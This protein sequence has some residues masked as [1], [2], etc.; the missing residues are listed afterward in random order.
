MSTGY[1]F[2]L[3]EGGEIV[4]VTAC[5]CATDADALL[6]ADVVLQAS[7]YPAVEIWS[8]PRRVGMLSKRAISSDANPLPARIAGRGIPR[9]FA[10]WGLFQKA[11]S[12]S[13]LSASR[14]L[15]NGAAGM[16]T[17]A[18]MLTSGLFRP[19][20]Q[21]TGRVAGEAFARRSATWTL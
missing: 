6:E 20:R 21:G 7:K 16:A 4:A 2:Y 1:K 12:S 19:C 10:R 17:S 13:A 8:G 18:R 5:Y 3:L 15:L 14:S 9:S 11:T